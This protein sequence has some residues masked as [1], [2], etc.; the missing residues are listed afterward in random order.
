MLTNNV[1][2]NL[3]NWNTF[4]FT[5]LKTFYFCVCRYCHDHEKVEN[6]HSAFSCDEKLNTTTKLQKQLF[7]QEDAPLRLQDLKSLYV[8]YIP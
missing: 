4:T 1:F 5:V 7:F 8:L 3:K 2:D 6:C